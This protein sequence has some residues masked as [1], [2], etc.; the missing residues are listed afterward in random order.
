MTQI[1]NAMHDKRVRSEEARKRK[2][3]QRERE[4]QAGDCTPG[5]AQP[6]DS[7]VA[8]APVALAAAPIAPTNVAAAL[9]SPTAA[10]PAP[11]FMPLAANNF[12]TAP[13]FNGPQWSLSNLS[14]QPSTAAQAQTRLPHLVSLLTQHSGPYPPAP[15][16]VA[17]PD[18]I[19]QFSQQRSIAASNSLPQSS[20]LIPTFDQRIQ[21]QQQ[22][23]PQPDLPASQLYPHKSVLAPTVAP[24]QPPLPVTS[25]S[26][27]QRPQTFLQAP[28]SSRLL[29][30][31]VGPMVARQPP[32][33]PPPPEPK[34]PCIEVQPPVQTRRAK[35]SA[36]DIRSFGTYECIV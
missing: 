31:A 17:Q 15:A 6:L 14:Q 9:G 18:Q 5:A 8:T 26:F 34:A 16:P 22:Q 20:F 10:A 19:S 21:Q 11:A 12:Q 33:P 3:E 1:E 27:E 29:P 30:A 28:E 23:Q 2:R 13:P 25:N 7:P 4:K 36:R 24:L 35:R 32:P